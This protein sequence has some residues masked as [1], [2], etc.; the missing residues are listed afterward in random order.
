M[1]RGKMLE[2]EARKF[3][4][5]AR[6]QEPTKVGFMYK[7]ESRMCGASPD[8]LVGEDGL[9]ELKVPMP[10]NHILWLIRD[11]MPKTHM[12]QV[13]FQLWV[14]GRSWCDFVSYCP[15]LPEFLIRH[16]PDDV[17]QEAFDKHIPVFIEEILE[18]RE[19]LISMGVVPDMETR[20]GEQ[21]KEPNTENM[22]V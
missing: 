15:N 5:F 12:P 3:Y 10:K 20:T 21:T 16:A 19:K 8:A 9:L 4:A 11:E 2:A 6:D 17:W 13:Q 1:E 18:G 14:S 22:W 7:D